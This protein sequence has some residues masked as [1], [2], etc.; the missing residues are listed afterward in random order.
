MMKMCK[1]V[2]AQLSTEY[3]K[4]AAS[5]VNSVIPLAAARCSVVIDALYY[6]PEGAG[7]I[8]YEVIGFSIDLIL[9][10][11]LWHWGRLSV[12]QK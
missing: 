8:P 12:S 9:P 11:A 4:L 2:R 10:A 6:K 5:A 1:G 3:L 7:S